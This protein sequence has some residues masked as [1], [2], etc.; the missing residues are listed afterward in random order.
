M[1]TIELPA[2]LAARLSAASESQQVP[3]SQIVQEA[4]ERV[5]PAPEFASPASA[6]TGETLY[7]QMKDFIGC[8]DAEEDL[9]TNRKYLEGFGECRN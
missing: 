9:A 6:A 4:L 2:A 8:I 5:L 3:P 7:E 1:V